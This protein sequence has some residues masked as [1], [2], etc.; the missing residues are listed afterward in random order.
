[1]FLF[2][3]KA[4]MRIQTPMSGVLLHLPHAREQQRVLERGEHQNRKGSRGCIYLLRIPC[5]PCT[6]TGHAAQYLT[7]IAVTRSRR[8]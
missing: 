4:G 8:S 6:L 1:M 5:T 2:G 7:E 3:Y